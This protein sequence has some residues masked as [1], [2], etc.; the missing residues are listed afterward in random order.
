MCVITLLSRKS[1]TLFGLSL[2]SLMELKKE[3][4]FNL[5]SNSFAFIK[6]TQ[7]LSFYTVVFRLLFYADL[8]CRPT[9]ISPDM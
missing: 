7:A 2:K 4:K 9:I 8:T 3:S 6:I 5:L 1:N